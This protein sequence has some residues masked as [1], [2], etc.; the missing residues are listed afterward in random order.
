MLALAVLF[1]QPLSGE[2]NTPRLFLGN[3]ALPPM[4]FMEDGKPV[5]VVV[6]LADAVAGRMKIP[7][8]LSYM[9][10]SLA[11]EL[12]QEGKADALL[13]INPTEERRG[14][15]DFSEPLLESE[16]SIFVRADK[17]GIYS[18]N[19]LRGTRVGVEEKGMPVSILNNFP[20]INLVFIPDIL[21]GMRGLS[22]GRLDAVIVDRW[23]GSYVLAQN[24][25]GGVRIAGEAFDRS[26]SAIAVK[27]GNRELLAQI[28]EALA[29][30]RADGTY[31][32]ILAKW[33]PREVVFQTRAQ[34][35]RQKSFLIVVVCMVALAAVWII[36]LWREMRK[37]KRAER[38]LRE[39]EAEFRSL[40][41]SSLDAVFLTAP[42][43]NVMG[44]NP[45]ASA[46]FGWTEAELCRMGRAGVMDMNDPR[47]PA[48]LEERERAGRAQ[49]R[50]LNAIRKNGEIFPVEIDSVILKGDPPHSFVIVRDISERLRREAHL[51]LLAKIGEDFAKLSS[52]EDIMQAVGSRVGQYLN[53]SN[54][55]FAEIDEDRDCAKIEWAW[56]RI[57]DPPLAMGV[58]QLSAYVSVGFRQEACAGKA[59]IIRNTQVDSRTDAGGHAAMNIHAYVAVPFHR[60]GKWQYMFTVNDSVPR[61]WR[62]DEVDLITEITNRT[63]PR[64]ERARAEAALKQ[65]N[66]VLEDRVQE[67]T[68][69]L[70]QRAAHL[71]A[72]AGELTLS[73]QRERR[74]LAKVLHDHLQQLLVG[75]KFRITILSRHTDPI[76]Q[77]AT[78]EIVQLLDE[79]I[80]ES[81]TLTSELSPPILHE[82]GLAAGLAWLARWMAD[83]HGLIVDLSVE[84]DIPSLAETVKVLLFESVRE[85][86]F[87]A[88]KHARAGSANV[89]VRCL[90][91]RQLRITVS[92]NGSGFDPGKLKKAGEIGGGFGL[93]SIRERLDLIGGQMEISSM[94]ER[95]SRFM[96]SVPFS[97]RAEIQSSR[98][99]FVPRMSS[100]DGALTVESKPGNPIRLLL[101]D[102]HAVLREGL[103][104]LLN[105]EP[106]IEVVG[107]AADGEEA[108]EMAARLLPDVILM[109]VSLPKLNGIEATRTISREF[110]EIR[111]IG[112][113]M[114]EAS[115]RGQAMR[116]AGAVGYLTK[117]GPS[118]DLVNMIRKCV[119]D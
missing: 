32:K 102:D 48:A 5:G 17:E 110:P 39:S 40:F 112:L 41:E 63:F 20:S 22:D 23:V 117:S 66:A 46:M 114:F 43:G 47:L 67:R 56:S 75:A 12:V 86:L 2:E 16:F 35:L 34:Y 80:Q 99:N 19:T 94:P 83:R 82:G 105:N 30:I 91:E 73:E 38:S 97:E 93:F 84:G 64:L 61:D 8:R 106:G 107:V 104:T 52:A 77:Q 72:L 92:D 58:R 87:N 79:S 78:R 4:I 24:H 111:V 36:F 7:V 90:Q 31:E 100:H 28:N 53:I 42:D 85:L 29:S 65:A 88:A 14:I 89:N 37:R 3:H 1:S 11:Q 98:P 119:K 13:Q 118:S 62:D 96:L 51:S 76:V 109:D 108:V 33:R 26:S 57:P 25:I 55:L 81:R 10:W 21:Q 60:V 95:G 59:I 69:E 9:N 71:R 68:A 115:E 103:A 6:D 113:S 101:A 74:R 70:E 116:D 54:C 50:E 18:L 49:R 44:A 15:Y 45:A 27:R